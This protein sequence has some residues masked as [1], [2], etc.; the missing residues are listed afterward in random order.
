[1]AVH[2]MILS[3]ILILLSSMHNFQPCDCWEL[4]GAHDERFVSA[5]AALIIARRNEERPRMRDTA[6]GEVNLAMAEMSEKIFSERECAPASSVAFSTQSPRPYKIRALD[7]SM[8]ASQRFNRCVAIASDFPLRTRSVACDRTR[9][10]VLARR[11]QLPQDS[12]DDAPANRA[13]AF[14][15]STPICKRCAWRKIAGDRCFYDRSA[16]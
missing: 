16:E 13:I 14:I 4:S 5:K 15:V 10:L 7:W 1:M 11:A 12:G 9:F 2:A 6:R 3:S 8:D